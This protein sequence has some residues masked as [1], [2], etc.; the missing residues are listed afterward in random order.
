M[1]GKEQDEQNAGHQT[2]GVQQ[3]DQRSFIGEL[4]GGK[5]VSHRD[6]LEDIAEGDPE[7]QGREEAG[8]DDGLVP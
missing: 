8:D 7:Q 5:V 1:D 2:V 6:A 4:Q 3:A